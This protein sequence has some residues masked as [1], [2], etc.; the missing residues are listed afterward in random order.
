MLN[1]VGHKQSEVKQAA[2]YG[3]GVLGQFGGPEFAPVCAQ[4]I[5]LLVQMIQ[6]P[7]SRDETRI[8]ATENAIAAVTKILKHNASAINVDEVLPVW[9]SWLPVWED[10]DEAPHVYGYLCDLVDANHPVVLGP[11]NAN[12]PNLMAIFSE[13]FRKE[14]VDKTDDVTKRMLNIVRQLQ[15]NP[16]MFQACVS[17]LDQEQQLALH[18]FLST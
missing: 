13:A 12:L 14:A 17:R 18:N 10:T 9:L 16:D 6:D 1:M 15:A 2:A 7:E 8:N 4:A 5:P 11:D 3:C